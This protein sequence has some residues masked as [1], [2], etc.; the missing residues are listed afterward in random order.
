MIEEQSQ[1]RTSD[2][3]SISTDEAYRLSQA[4]FKGMVTQALQD[5][6]RDISAL[7]NKIGGMQTDQRIRNYI[8]M[9]IAGMSGIIAGLFSKYLTTPR[10]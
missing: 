1:M 2:W 5:I 8:N 3:K 7:D 6:R 10:L 9:G 4:E